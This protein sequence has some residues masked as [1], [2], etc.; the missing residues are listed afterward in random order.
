MLINWGV[1]FVCFKKSATFERQTNF[2]AKFSRA[3]EERINNYKLFFKFHDC[4]LLP[5][6]SGSKFKFHL[7]VKN[8]GPSVWQCVA[9]LSVQGQTSLICIM[10]NL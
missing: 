4:L 5:L 8:R 2:E 7:S 9:N 6:C 3:G 1:L 10:F